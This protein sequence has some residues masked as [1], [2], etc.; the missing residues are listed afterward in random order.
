[1]TGQLMIIDYIILAVMVVSVVVG[2]WR[3][4]LRE[5]IS[6]AAWIAAFVI[7][8]A[9][10]GDAAAF[11]QPYISIPSIR[12]ILAF[13]GLF[14]I[15]IV[16]G[17]LVNMLATRIARYSG[18]GI[19]NR[20]VG[21]FFGLV[22]GVALVSLLILAVRLTPVPEDPWWRTSILAPYFEP[23]A[24]VLQD[25][26]PADFARYFLPEGEVPAV[27]PAAAADDTSSAPVANQ[28]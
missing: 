10:V 8:F 15:T 23:L 27:A 4:F 22:R 3:G 2:L 14:V 1:M 28:N 5:F 11:L 19:F 9:F 12:T 17:A 25:L 21:M 6:L 13:G 18:L 26:L 20:I 7:A 16:L 24:D